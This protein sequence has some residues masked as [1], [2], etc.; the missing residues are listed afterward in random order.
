MLAYARR[1]GDEVSI[2]A[3]NFADRPLRLELDGPWRV[4]VSSDRD[5]EG[6]RFSGHLLGE[7]ALLLRP[8]GE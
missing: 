4:V 6:E 7:Q 1:A 2:T 5:G 3:V 8:E